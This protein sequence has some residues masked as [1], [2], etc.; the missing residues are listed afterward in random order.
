LF[1][2]WDD[3]FYEGVILLDVVSQDRNARMRSVARLAS[4]IAKLCGKDS[5]S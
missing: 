1:V 3:G 2:E 4:L 5:L